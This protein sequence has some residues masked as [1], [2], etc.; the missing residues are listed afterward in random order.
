MTDTSWHTSI[1]G[2][3]RQSD[4]RTTLNNNFAAARRM[5][6]VEIDNTD[7]P[8]TAGDVDLIVCDCT[9]GAITVNLPAGTVGDSYTVVKIDG[10]ANN[11]TIDGD[12]TDT[13]NGATT[14]SITAQWEVKRVTLYASGT[15]VETD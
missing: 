4:S 10:I 12:G 15:W 6:V 2:S 13:I 7:S 3:G 11:V 5:T 9:G 1:S 8:Y 14:A